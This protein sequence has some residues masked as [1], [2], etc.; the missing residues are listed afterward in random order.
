MKNK[1]FTMLTCAAILFFSACS[2]DEEPEVAQGTKVTYTGDVKPLLTASCTPCHVAGGVHPYKWDDYSVTKSKISS[3]I[4][5]V[6]RDASASGFMPQGGSKLS[7]ASI[8]IL[9]KWVTDGL[10]EK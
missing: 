1:L 6:G 7:A 5:R 4:D 9:N 2:K 10:T 8:A 3:I